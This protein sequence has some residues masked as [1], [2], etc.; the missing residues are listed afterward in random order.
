ME[1]KQLWPKG[2]FNQVMS[3][4]SFE[5]TTALPSNNS[6]SPSWAVIETVAD[7]EGV[8]ETELPPLYEVCDP[9]AL[10]ALFQPSRERNV[11]ALN[12]VRFQYCGYTVCVDAQGRVLLME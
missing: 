7:A 1:V 12:E 6:E 5:S 10:D 4:S 9:E 8:D 11:E 2:A 3:E